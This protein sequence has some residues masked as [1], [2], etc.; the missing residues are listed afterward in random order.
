MIIY[1]TTVILFVHPGLSGQ[2]FFF[3]RCHEIKDMMPDPPL[4]G[5]EASDGVGNAAAASSFYLVA[6]YSL[7]CYDDVWY[8]MRPYTLFVVIVF[9][10]GLPLVFL[11]LLLRYRKDIRMIAQLDMIENSLKKMVSFKA[12][13]DTYDV[14]GDGAI[15]PPELRKAMADHGV[16]LS[17]TEIAVIFNRID[18][19]G[20]GSISK[21]TSI[22][23]LNLVFITL[24]HP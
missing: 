19:D 21:V 3:F 2:A 4:L 24:N 17:E 11:I 22:R 12:S 5:V 23:G 13:F 14:D 7:E 10:F 6:D 18:V 15:S 9:S 20:D 8:A 1:S 16:K